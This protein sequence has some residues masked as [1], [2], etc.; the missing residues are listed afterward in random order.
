M[1]TQM[2]KYVKKIIF[3]NGAMKET[4]INMGV[5]YYNDS[6]FMTFTSSILER[7]FQKVFFRELVNLGLDVT[8][9]NN[10]L[11]A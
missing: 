4:P 9:E 8:L 1:P 11:E 10:D 6:I 2:Q 7:D 5:T 3:S